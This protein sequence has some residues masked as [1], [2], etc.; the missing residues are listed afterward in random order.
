MR[1]DLNIN[2]RHVILSYPGDNLKKMFLISTDMETEEL[3]RG[4]EELNND[5]CLFA[6][7]GLSDWN[8]LLSPWYSDPVFKGGEAFE[9]QADEY[10]KELTE[11][12]IPEIKKEINK[13]DIEIVI[14]GYSLA[15]LFA[16]YAM[17]KCDAFCGCI[18]ASG[19]LWFPGFAEYIM[20]HDILKD[21]PSIYLSLGD[22][23]ANTKNPVLQKVQEVTQEAYELYKSKG[24]NCIFELNPGNHFVGHVE[25]VIKGIKWHI[26]NG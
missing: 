3:V 5:D 13:S 23:E 2:G 6:V 25:R 12:I 15:G 18:S 24:Y 21:N 20:E 4:F 8:G 19:S 10:L 11:K 22:R 9:G 14:T 26:K 1:K 17:Y 16:L 7:V